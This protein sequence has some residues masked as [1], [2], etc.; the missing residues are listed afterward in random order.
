M[1]MPLCQRAKL[2]HEDQSFIQQLYGLFIIRK[3]NVLDSVQLKIMSEVLLLK[4][5]QEVIICKTS[6]HCMNVL[7]A[8]SPPQMSILKEIV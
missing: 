5:G 4:K 1:A 6:T 7:I 8:F 2:V 3:E